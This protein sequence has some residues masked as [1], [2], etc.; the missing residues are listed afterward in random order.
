M[1]SLNS[2]E[3]AELRRHELHLD[4]ASARLAADARRARRR[5]PRP[6]WLRRVAGRWRGR[7]AGTAPATVTPAARSVP[8]DGLA[9][10]FAAEGSAA[11][12][13]ELSGFV[14]LAAARGATPTLLSVLVDDDQPDVAR[15]RAL[16]RVVAELTSP[17]RGSGRERPD[18][19][20]AA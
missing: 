1:N 4:A 8:F 14:A 11:V 18:K 20:D 15:Q 16:Q 19:S 13:D 7:Q 3:L 9:A 10:R 2:L 17:A 6:D 12:R 5:R